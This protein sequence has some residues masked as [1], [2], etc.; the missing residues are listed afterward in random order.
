MVGLVSLL[1]GLV[2]R[3]FLFSL[4]PELAASE[5]QASPAYTAHDGQV[6]PDLSLLK[7]LFP[8]RFRWKLF[9]GLER[10][11]SSPVSM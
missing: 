3:Y 8:S 4:D 9:R 5:D 7:L 2:G 6:T 10:V 11:G 1:G